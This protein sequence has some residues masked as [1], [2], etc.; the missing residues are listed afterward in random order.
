MSRLRIGCV[1][2]EYP[3]DKGGVAAYLYGLFRT[4]QAEV[5]VVRPRFWGLWPRWLPVIRQ[6]LDL[7]VDVLV[8]SHVLPIG[9]AAWLAR[10]WGGPGYVLILHGMD[11]LLASRSV[12]KRWLSRQIVRDAYLVIT[13]SE[14]TSGLV[15]THFQRSSLVLTPGYAPRSLSSKQEAR[16]KLGIGLEDK[17]IVSVGRLV[18]RKGFDVLIEACKEL[19][20]KLVIIGNGPDKSRLE[21]LVEHGMRDAHCKTLIIA[22]AMDEERDL[23]YAAADV[24]ALLVREE[25]NDVEGF[26]IV[27]LEAAAAGLPIVAGKSGGVSEAVL[28][29]ETGWL[30]E[31]GSAQ[32]ARRKI[33]Q[34]LQDSH[35]AQTMGQTGRQRILE[36]FRWETRAESLTNRLPL[37]SIIVPVFNRARVLDQ[38]LNCLRQQSYRHFEVI[39]VDDGSRE[40]I[41]E[42]FEKYRFSSWQYFRQENQGAPRA[43]NRGFERSQGQYILFL[44]ADALLRPDALELMVKRMFEQPDV[45]VVYSDFHFGWKRFRGRPFSLEALRKGNFIHTTALMRREVFFGFDESLKRFQDWD[46]WLTIASKGTEFAWIPQSLFRLRT[47]GTM[48]K[49]LPAFI[50]RLPWQRMGWMPK[51]L[52]DY[53]LAERVIQKKHDLAS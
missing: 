40:N 51:R 33:E 25:K 17:V 1:T 22:Q 30:V 2:L 16:I 24:F 32:D 39:V 37:V 49:W 5:E 50:H 6:C 46:L 3:P 48:S 4:L 19:D 18:S 27:Y 53:K 11:V 38:C 8:I 29:G 45:S 42:V 12:F 23:W 41:S 47:G 52:Q 28:D 9:A 15:K 36:K 20:A 7:R 35:R 44:D 14:Y 13:N 43:R 34:L 31:P 21:E 26:G 10:R